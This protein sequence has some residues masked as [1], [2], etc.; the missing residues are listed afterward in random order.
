MN[1]IR[2]FKNEAEEEK[3]ELARLSSFV[4]AIAIGDLVKSTLGP[5]GMDK[6]LVSHGRSMG[7]V[8]VTNDGATILKSIGVDNPAAKILVDMSKV[9]DDEVGDGTTSVTVLAAELLREAEKLI[10]TKIHPQTI[11]AG[12]RKATEIARAALINAAQDHSNDP[13]KFKEDLMNI[14]RTTLSSKILSQHKEQFAT[15]AVDAILRLK[16][17][18][19]LTAIQLIKKS[20]G[21]LEESFLDEGF[22]LDKKPGVHQPKRIENAQILI[23]NTPM[24]TDKIKV[25]GSHIKVDSMA[26][27]A[28]LEMAEKEK[29]RD[30]VNK[31]INHKCNVFINR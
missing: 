31:I 20:G 25:F 23:A 8:E 30:K 11:I 13:E 2:I 22:L 1:P 3:A 5:K 17:S 10:A 9:Q 29:M 15:L 19:E 4:G 7:S 12:W 6:I 26:K 18:C 14:A 24:D 27:I 16:G 21:T 28:D